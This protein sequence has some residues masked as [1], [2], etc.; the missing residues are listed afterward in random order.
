MYAMVEVHPESTGYTYFD[1]EE[2]GFEAQA[3]LFDYLME[4]TNRAPVVVDHKDLM[5][6]PRGTLEKF[7]EAMGIHFDPSML[8]FTLPLPPHANGLWCVHLL[9]SPPI[10][11]F[12]ALVRTQGWFL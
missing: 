12:D 11:C 9:L 6:D 2:C 4:R 1:A 3:E 10:I 7:C 8:E 5:L